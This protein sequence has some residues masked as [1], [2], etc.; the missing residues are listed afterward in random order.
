MRVRSLLHPRCRRPNRRLQTTK[1][2]NVHH[3]EKPDET[4]VVIKICTN[5]C[6]RTHTHASSVTR[7][8][9]GRVQVGIGVPFLKWASCN[10]IE[11]ETALTTA[12]ARRRRGT[13]DNGGPGNA[14]NN[15]A[16]RVRRVES[17]RRRVRRVRLRV[18]PSVAK[19][20]RTRGRG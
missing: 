9:L 20:L 11:I 10:S 2:A 5:V 19:E 15:S 17:I 6:R 18:Q 7:F 8:R 3:R 14:D 4:I 16:V 12:R 13:N 1:N